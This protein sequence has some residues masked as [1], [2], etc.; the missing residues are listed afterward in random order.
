MNKIK[1]TKKKVNLIAAVIIHNNPS[2]NPKLKEL[3]K[4][5]ILTVSTRSMIPK[6]NSMKNIFDIY[7]ISVKKSQHC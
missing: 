3:Q 1:I 7:F 5:L 4:K 6:E 2:Q